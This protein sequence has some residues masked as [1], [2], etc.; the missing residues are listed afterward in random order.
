MKITISTENY[1]VE[2]EES[3]YW[4]ETKGDCLGALQRVLVK[5]QWP[6]KEVEGATKK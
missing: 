4:E 3:E 1:K 6:N 2:F 5:E